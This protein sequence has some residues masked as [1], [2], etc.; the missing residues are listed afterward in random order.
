[1]NSVSRSQHSKSQFSLAKSS[2]R[3]RFLWPLLLILPALLGGGS[4]FA[5]VHFDFDQKF[6]VHPDRQVWDFSITREDS[7]YHIF[8]HTIHTETPHASYGDTIW[9]ATS[10]N[11]KQWTIEGPVLIVGQ[12]EFDAGALWAPDVFYN[13]ADQKWMLAYTAC[14]NQ[15]NQRIAMASSPDLYTWEKDPGNPLVEPDPELYTYDPD[16]W[17][18]NFRDPY[19]FENGGTYHL[20]VTAKQWLGEPTGIIYHAISMDLQNWVDI[21]PMFVH[22]GVDRW[23]VLESPQYKVLDDRYYLFF[24]EY[25]TGGISVIGADL[26]G[27]WTM[28]DREFIDYGYAPEVDEFDQ[29]THIFSRIAPYQV[30][31]T[32][33]IHYAVRLDTLQVN[34]DGSVEALLPHPLDADWMERT[35]TSTLAQPTFGDNP[36]MRGG[37]SAGPV[38]NG[39]FASAEYYQ[40]PLSGRGS[41]GTQL[42]DAATGTLRSFPFRIEG[43]RMTLLVGGGNYPETCRVTLRDYRSDIIIY[44]ETGED[45]ELMTLRQWDLSPYQGHMVYL[46][47]VDDETGP[48]GHLNVDEIKEDFL[49]VSSVQ[50][51]PSGGLAINCRAYPNPFNPRTTISFDL[52]REHYAMVRIHDLKGRLVWNSPRIRGQAGTNSVA[53]NGVDRTGHNAAAGTYLYSV[54]VDG[55]AA[56][57]GK[58]VLVK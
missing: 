6:F 15:M 28:A 33:L 11:L 40:G 32:E 46:E 38:G 16:G 5:L 19:I 47:I 50:D 53:W 20:I 48:F 44:S 13:Q 25:D 17:W 57:Q 31:A 23:R 30:P 52:E 7:L 42:G 4:A 58:I 37:D 45:Q 36:A 3:L 51:L 26:P 9:H 8:Y 2:A 43:T 24:G 1:M 54:L 18:S 14:D 21:G 56:G 34:P 35:G 39:F 55:V 49:P 27:N 12:N 41:P 10:S 22:D 29:G